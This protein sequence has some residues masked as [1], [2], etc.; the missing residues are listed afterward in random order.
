MKWIHRIS[1]IYFIASIVVLGA[2]ITSYVMNHDAEGP[3]I[4]IPEGTI[5]LNADSSTE[6]ILAGVTALDGR[7]GD[8]S[9]SLMIE[10]ISNIIGDNQRE[11]GIVAFDKDGNVSKAKRMVQYNY[12][13]IVFTL[14][15]PLRFPAGTN[16][17]HIKNGLY[18]TDYFD[19][20]ISRWIIMNNIDNE[21]LNTSTVG[22][23]QVEFSV[24]NSV[25]DVEK[26][27]ATVEIYNSSQEV[28][29]PKIT[30]KQYLKYL[31]S[32]EAFNPLD[33]IET[34]VCDGKLYHMDVVEEADI[35]KQNLT[36]TNSIV[37][38][39]SGWYEVEYKIVDS[40]EN[41][42]IVRLIVCVAEK[43]D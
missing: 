30:L 35:I 9:D 4:S 10:N 42:K 22:E 37:R 17:T 20:N 40:L 31:K 41:E 3:V 36:V 11:V 25:G 5:I 24:A 6:E 12:T 21:I 18:A 26:F 1:I 38:S 39:Q 27:T 14:Q 33:Y 32:G 34:V 15:E 28:V 16:V 19:G 8:V 43:E 2:Y 23:Y 29:A 7:D 13:G